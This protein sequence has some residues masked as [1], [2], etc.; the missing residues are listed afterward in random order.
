LAVAAGLVVGTAAAAP[1]VTPKIVFP[2]VGNVTYI[3]DFGAPRGQGRHEGIDILAAKKAPAVAAEAGKVKFWTTS[4]RAG[5]MLYLY[6]RSG[7]TYLYIHLNNDLTSGN[8]NKGK[9]VAGTSYAK[10]LKDG[11]KVQAG[12]QIGY[13]GDSGDANGIHAHLHFEVHPND[14]GA[15]DPYSY[16]QAAQK[17][18]FTAPAGTAFV[19]ELTGKVVSAAPT[20]LAVAVSTV[21]AWPMN[22]K[23]TKVART[24]TLTVPATTLVQS[25]D[26]P[27]LT[28]S[29]VGGAP[30]VV[31]TQ[32]AAATLKAMRG[33]AG[34]LSAALVQLG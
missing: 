12:Q 6:G 17:L 29:A 21:Q 8:D 14:K 10:G 22:M 1:P 20:R 34:A 18:L 13:V 4:A 15:V 27:E 31:W 26:G 5:C 19:L 25:P 33:D 7:T 32:P 16:L 11:A 24:V 28:T 23:L 30:V 2:V 3:D 9:C